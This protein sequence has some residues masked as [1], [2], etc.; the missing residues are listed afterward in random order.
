MPAAPV[1][2]VRQATGY[3][4]TCVRIANPPAWRLILQMRAS[5]QQLVC[6]IA[7]TYTGLLRELNPGPL[8]PEARIMP[9]DQAA[10]GRLIF[11]NY[12]KPSATIAC[13]HHGICNPAL[14]RGKLHTCAQARGRGATPSWPRGGASRKDAHK[15][16][17]RRFASIAIAAAPKLG[18]LCESKFAAWPVRRICRKPGVDWVALRCRVWRDATNLDNAYVMLLC[19]IGLLRELNP[20][21]L[22]P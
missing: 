9:L 5:C 15:L 17:C 3:E 1:A 4:P 18:M 10:A 6:S 12:Y 2:R 19:N 13:G 11:P 20:G 14:L 7:L 16:C 21:P 8:A 22:A